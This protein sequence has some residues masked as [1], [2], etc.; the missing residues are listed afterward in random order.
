MST[1]HSGIHGQGTDEVSV[2]QLA[3]VVVGEPFDDLAC[4][5]YACD[6]GQPAKRAPSS[7]PPPSFSNRR[8]LA[9]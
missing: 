3:L 1:V 9:H 8:E 2:T 6:G 5:S 7:R 4:R